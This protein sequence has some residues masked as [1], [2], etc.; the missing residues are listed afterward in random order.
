MTK[1]IL[2]NAREDEKS[3]LASYQAKNKDMK[4]DIHFEELNE[5]NMH[6]ITSDYDA[7]CC[8]QVKAIPE[9][10]Y[11]L[12]KDAGIKVFATRSAGYDMYRLDLLK[13]YG[14][15]FTRVPAY[16]PNAIAEFALSGVMY[17]SRNHDLIA[18][19]QKKGDF[20]WQPSIISQEMRNKTVGIIGTGN[21]GRNAARLFKG[22]GAKVLGYDLYPNKAAEEYLSYVDSIEE[23]ISTCDVISLHM[24]ATAENHHMFNAKTFETCKDNLILVNTARGALVDTPAL[25]EA[26]EAK[27]LRA[28]VIDT[29]EFEGPYVNKQVDLAKIEDKVFAQLL[30]REDILYSPHVAFY[31]HT[32]IENLVHIAL[33]GAYAILTAGSTPEEVQL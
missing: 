9:E 25:I 32:A 24:P 33:D 19:N 12:M 3:A 28:A 27:K 7:I 14:I 31:T 29:Y 1:V 30:E 6:L 11:K 23:I 20:R 8:S 4:L 26:L 13:E 18:S 2:F 10:A 15:R 22:T 5:T 17:F 16:S 21:I